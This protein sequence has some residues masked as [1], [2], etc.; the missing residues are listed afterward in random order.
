MAFDVAEVRDRAQRLKRAIALE[1]YETRAGLK[2][3]PGFARIY[4]EHQFL[5]APQVLPA[6]QRELAEADG[7]ARRRLTTLFN[8]VAIQRV[9]AELAPLEDELRTW[10]ADA[11]IT[12]AG[13]E[14]PFRRVAGAIVR[15]DRR[16]ERLAWEAARSLRV[17]EAASLRL[18][19]VHRE[20]EAVS[21]LGLG[22]YVEA[23]ERLLGLNL[24]GME[25]FAVEIL[26]RTEDP[27]RRAFLQQVGRRIGTEARAAARSDATWLMGMRWLAQPFAINPLLSRLRRDL[28]KMGLPLPRDGV[29]RLDLDRRPLK[30]GASF[31]APIQVPGDVVLVVSPV[32][33]W[34]DARSLLHEIGHTLHFAY[35]SPSLPWEERALGDTAVTESF[36]LLFESL[37]LDG[38]WVESSTGLTGGAL[39]EYLALAGFLQLYELRRHAAQFLWEMELAA[40]DT[41]GELAPRYASLMSDAT[42]FSHDP[43]T[44]LEGVRRGFWVARQLRAWMLSAIMLDALHDRFAGGWYTDPA[45]GQFLSEILSAGQRE[46]ASDLANQLGDKRLTANS[47]LEKTSQWLD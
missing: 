38:G 34:A 35:T 5:L 14:V 15:A 29:V 44:Y 28:E 43:S 9:E 23:W 2:G 6:I 45:A 20:R 4:A 42:G 27:Y 17:E 11:T 33:G 30:Q 1:R 8:W 3:R 47:L 22:S 41:P 40:S 24:R 7:D 26:A 16:G 21:Q 46:D 36:A 31:C 13:V 18:D 37:T 19:V 10:E 32:G 25:R 39:D 12:L